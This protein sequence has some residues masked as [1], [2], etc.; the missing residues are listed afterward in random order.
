MLILAEVEVL[1]RIGGVH[2]SLVF[3]VSPLVAGS[4]VENLA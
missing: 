1:L 4:V 2:S 3:D